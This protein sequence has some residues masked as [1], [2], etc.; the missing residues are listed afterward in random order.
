MSL[1]NG[2]IEELK[3]AGLTDNIV[4]YGLIRI[5][6]VVDNIPTTRFVYLTWIG[7]KVSGI[8][9]ARI[10]VN[11]TAVT[12]IIGHYSIEYL[13][14]T[15]EEISESEIVGRVQDA[16]GSRV[17]VLDT[18]KN[19]NNT[20]SKPSG[21]FSIVPKE[22]GG[23]KV[24]DDD[25]AKD[26]IKKIRHK[27]DGLNWICLSYA[28]REELSVSGS[29]SGGLDELRQHL[30]DN[31]VSY[32]FFSTESTIDSTEMRRFIYLRWVPENV[33]PLL[34]GKLTTH[35]G[36]CEDYFRPFHI[37]IN[38][39]DLNEITNDIVNEKISHMTGK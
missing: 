38:A 28:S 9:N 35:R 27:E 4:A 34:K 22:Q 20:T 31:Q 15:L 18:K 26:L 7:Q 30:K 33:S 16:S 25:L 6:D 37:N 8:T 24:L 10:G 13:A 21:I 12:G 32:G 3:N 17:R 19:Q 36:F 39:T 2:G 5:V 11:K 23:L 29:G 1:G 14:S